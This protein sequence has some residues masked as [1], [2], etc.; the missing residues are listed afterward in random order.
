[1]REE[2]G[3]LC[4][5]S[6][7]L[8]LLYTVSSYDLYDRPKTGLSCKEFKSRAYSSGTNRGC[9][10]NVLSSTPVDEV[11]DDQEL[12]ISTQNTVISNIQ[13]ARSLSYNNNFS[14][15]ATDFEIGIRNLQN[16]NEHQRFLK[17][18]LSRQKSL[19]HEKKLIVIGEN[20]NMSFLNL[21]DLSDMK[22]IKLLNSIELDG[23]LEL[24]LRGNELFVYQRTYNLI[25][26]GISC[27]D[28]NYID[29]SK[30]SSL[31]SIYKLDLKES[32]NSLQHNYT[33]YGYFKN[34]LDVQNQYLYKTG[35]YPRQTAILKLRGDDTVMTKLKGRISNAFSIKE[36]DE[37]LIVFTEEN[38]VNS[39]KILN[40]ELSKINEISNIA[41]GES[42]FST[43][44]KQ[45]RAYLVTFEDVDPLFSIDITNVTSPKILGELKIPGVS[46]YLHVLSDQ[47]LL[48]FGRSQGRW[49]NVEVS[50][51]DVTSNLAPKRVDLIILDGIDYLDVFRQHHGITVHNNIISLKSGKEIIVLKFV[52]E[53]L[54]ELGRIDTIMYDYNIVLINKELH[55]YEYNGLR[56][57]SLEQGVPELAW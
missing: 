43:R 42:I 48:G 37:H 56:I 57:F 44:I 18:N 2:E 21:Y 26:K 20:Q 32:D 31:L 16:G 55:L 8:D 9:Y 22:E 23:F 35:Y 46:N 24:K 13:E 4:D 28:I 15:K 38:Q 27:E 39:M 6:D 50:L 25:P 34:H 41:P 7:N 51:F 33:A 45:N 30:G 52:D 14:F 11:Q 12:D 10:E 5:S 40:S 17:T 19:L 47:F 36:K 1:M 29:N 49:G 54:V 53:S 3:D